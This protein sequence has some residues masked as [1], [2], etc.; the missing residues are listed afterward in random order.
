MSLC[1]AWRI[2]YLIFWK[3]NS[4]SSVWILVTESS[5]WCAFWSVPVS[6]SPPSSTHTQDYKAH[7]VSLQPSVHNFGLISAPSLL[8]ISMLR[9]MF[10]LLIFAFWAS[11]PDEGR[12]NCKSYSLEQE[13]GW[14]QLK[15]WS[16]VW[17]GGSKAEIIS[18]RFSSIYLKKEQ[19]A[20]KPCV[21]WIKWN[22][23]R[24]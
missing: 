11:L 13:R 23:R 15:M 9:L 1:S 24:E 5:R 17:S 3:V 21:Y 10:P 20:R 14:T 12:H 19:Q 22:P 18:S 7:S 4:W 16:R 8:Q 2:L 6:F